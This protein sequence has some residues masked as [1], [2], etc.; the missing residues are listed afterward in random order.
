VFLISIK[1]SNNFDGVKFNVANMSSL[2]NIPSKMPYI[3]LKSQSSTF[4]SI[5]SLV[6]VE[7]LSNQ[8]TYFYIIWLVYCLCTYVNICLLTDSIWNSS[9]GVNMLCFSISIRNF[10]WE[11]KKKRE[12]EKSSCVFSVGA[13]KWQ[14]LLPLSN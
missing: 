12:R 10:F 8:R 11:I 4:K 2:V 9:S 1:K 14:A 13:I 7:Y 5:I 3:S 6:V